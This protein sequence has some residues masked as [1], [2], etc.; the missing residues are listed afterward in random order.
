MKHVAL[1]IP[2]IDRI[3]GA[4]RQVLVLAEG[5]AARGWR[6]TVVALT[7]SGGTAAAALRAHGV[8]YISLKMRKGLADPRG[9]WRFVR[10]ASKDRPDIVHGHLPHAACFARWSRLLV[11]GTAVLDTVHTANTGG[12][13]RRW[14]YRI[15]DRLTDV[16]TAVSNAAADAYL[17]QNMVN[18]RHL[19]VIP[20]GIDLT[21]WTRAPHTNEGLRAKLGVRAEFLWLAAGRM[22]P[23]KDYPTLLHAIAMLDEP[24]H[25]A[26]A[27]SG[28]CYEAIRD[29][30]DELHIRSRISFLGFQDDLKQW[31]LA[32]NGF[33]LSSLWEGLP[34]A[35]M[36]ASACELPI[37]AT[38]VSGVREV[39]LPGETGFL[40]PSADP[41]ALA[42]AMRKL[43]H[44]SAKQ[45]TA[46][47]AVGRRFIAT[48]YSLG[49]VLD[50]WESI[51]NELLA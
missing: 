50:R 15:S 32:A 9:L 17:A 18:S 45:R 43:A 47:G 2:S 4:E 7:G 16:V 46:M 26:I 42:D 29:L 27:G 37:V 12:L 41:A 21:Q 44:M 23:V 34:M 11:S 35:I 28:K 39:V 31:M 38:D 40:A 3:G 1:L 51:Y 49:Y 30:A 8:G 13:G 48:R 19:R 25:L 5:L 24:V 22:E 14:G 33:V 20:N 10:W 36:E 6:I